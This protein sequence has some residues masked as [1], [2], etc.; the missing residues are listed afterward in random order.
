MVISIAIHNVKIREKFVIKLSVRPIQYKTVNVMKNH[1]GI[2]IV[3]IDASLRHI[4]INT[5]K[6]TNTIV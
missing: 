5:H 6:K 2:I 1:N 4:K 3:A